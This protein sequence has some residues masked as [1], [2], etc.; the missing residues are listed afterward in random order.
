[1]EAMQPTTFRPE[2]DNV[3]ARIIAAAADL[4]A[5]LG[6]DAATTRAVSAAAAVQAPTIYRLFGDKDGLLDA[7]AEQTLAEYVAGKSQQ[8]PDADPV[9]ELQQAWDTHI[10]FGLA[11]PAVFALIS[12]PRTRPASGAALAGL[13]VLR[14]RVRSVA[15]TGRLLVTEELAVD[16][17]HAIGT[18]TILSLLE[19]P[20]NE[21]EGLTEA[22]RDA[23]FAFIIVGQSQSVAGGPAGAAS[24]LRASIGDVEALTS[25]ERHFLDELLVRIALAS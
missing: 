16:L 7:V 25:G 15:L 4:I 24:A 8:D 19:K 3:R 1:M 23:V 6:S 11:H 21:R 20:N 14:D 10:A 18:G 9:V 22:A 12:A 2:S 17:I 13:A 5:T